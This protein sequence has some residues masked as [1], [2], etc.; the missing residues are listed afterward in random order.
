LNSQLHCAV[1]FLDPRNVERIVNA[2]NDQPA[3][4]ARAVSQSDLID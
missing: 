2:V 4:N 1:N 3:A